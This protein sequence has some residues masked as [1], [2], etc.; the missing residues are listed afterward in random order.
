MRCSQIEIHCLIPVCT[1]DLAVSVLYASV[2]S[3]VALAK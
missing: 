1:H 3:I 2:N